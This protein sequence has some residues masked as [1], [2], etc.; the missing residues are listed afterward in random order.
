MRT[1]NVSEPSDAD[2]RRGI[3]VANYGRHAEVLTSEGARHSCLLA[4][5]LGLTPVAGDRVQFRAAAGGAYLTAIEPRARVIQRAGRR[6]GETRVLAAHVDVMLIVSAVEPPFKE[7]LVDRYLVTAGVAGIAPV[8]VLNKIDLDSGRCAERVA[9]YAE[10]GYATRLV[11]A[12]TGEG[13]DRL[14]AGLA[15]RLELQVSY[16]IGVAEPLSL[17]IETFGTGRIPDEAILELI[18]KHFDFRPAAMIRDLDLRRPIYR[19]T[20]AYGHFGRDDID[21]PWERTDKAE[22]LREEAGL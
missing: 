11:S 13:K 7:G 14:A 1:S 19:A 17:A 20:A 15:D 12:K 4:A 5:D 22:T 9:L 6:A 8:V 21:A 18:E 10:L 3:V 2:L 16:A